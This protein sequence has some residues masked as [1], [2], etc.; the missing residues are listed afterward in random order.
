MAPRLNS[1]PCL[2]LK[3]RL[4]SSFFCWSTLKCEEI[5]WAAS[6]WLVILSLCDEEIDIIVSAS[7]T[8]VDQPCRWW[9]YYGSAISPD[10]NL[11]R[12]GCQCLFSV[13]SNWVG[14]NRINWVI[15]LVHAGQRCQEMNQRHESILIRSSGILNHRKEFISCSKSPLWRTP[16]FLPR[17]SFKLRPIWVTIKTLQYCVN[18]W[19]STRSITATHSPQQQRQEVFTLST[20]CTIINSMKQLPCLLFSL[21]RLPSF[22]SA[23][24]HRHYW[25]SS[26][27]KICLSS[28]GNFQTDFHDKIPH[29]RCRYLFILLW[30]YLC[31]SY[32]YS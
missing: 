18:N 13:W 16:C 17:I 20:E 30:N 6:A 21:R 19:H 10:V 5:F 3:D 23:A 2:V 12:I 24:D 22:H 27:P 15:D 32:F 4:F 14:A 8:R 25:S 28:C 9:C 7:P 11:S 1:F 31:A 29:S 26:S